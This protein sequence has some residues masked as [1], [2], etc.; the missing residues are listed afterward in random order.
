[1]ASGYYQGYVEND[2]LKIYQFILQ[3]ISNQ[4]EIQ[5][6]QVDL[7]LRRLRKRVKQSNKRHGNEKSA[8]LPSSTAAVMMKI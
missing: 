6:H 8:L 5:S 4:S 2:D 7:S 3:F 1:M